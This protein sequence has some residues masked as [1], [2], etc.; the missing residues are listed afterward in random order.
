MYAEITKALNGIKDNIDIILSAI[1]TTGSVVPIAEVESKPSI[2][3][4]TAEAVYTPEKLSSIGYNDLKKLAKKLGIS[5]SGSRDE[6]TA[7]ILGSSAETETE[8]EE[9][10]ELEEV[11]EVEDDV[12]ESEAEEEEDE[13]EDIIERQVNEAVAD[14]TNEEILDFLTDV[15]I[16]AKGKRQ[17]LIA[18]VVKAVRDGRIELDDSDE[19]D[20]SGEEEVEEG[21]PVTSN[22]DAE[23][24]PNDLD[25]P[26][27]TDARRQAIEDNDNEV[28]DA[29][30]HKDISREDIVE[31][32]NDFL[33][34]DVSEKSNS[35][36]VD[37][38]IYYTNLLIDDEGNLIEEGAYL[39]NNIPYCCGTPL[40]YLEEDNVYICEKCG[41]E[42][43]AE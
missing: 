37:M 41:T 11:E 38:Y 10:E 3:E 16:R 8:E 21:I 36:V 22:D 39:V 9:L 20:E 23:Y 2:V 1:S 26:E 35:E 29:I 25:N 31:W 40:K 30:K 7:R 42:Y 17:A 27:M 14:M 19:S 15:G 43:E 13:E 18:T 4:E 28:R 34:T 24:D 12:L 33:D 5:A 32:L 6:I